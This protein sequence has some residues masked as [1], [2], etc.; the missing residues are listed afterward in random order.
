MDERLIR[1]YTENYM[2]KV[3]YYCLKR[4]GSGTE[5]DDLAGDITQQI[6][7]ALK[8]GVVPEHFPAWV[9]QISHNRYR[10][11]AEWK[12]RHAER[13][14]DADI[15]T[16]E[17]TETVSDPAEDAVLG[18]QLALLRRELALIRTDYR[19]ILTA[20]YLENRPVR[21]IARSLSLSESAVKKRLERAR[22]LLKEGMEM[23]RT[24]GKL[25]YQPEN[26][27]FIN[28]G[29]F[30]SAGEPWNYI[31]RS[32]CKNILLAAYRT[33]STAEELSL[34]L[35]VALPYMEEELGSLV[36]A[37]LMKKNG[38]LY[39]TTFFI[40]SAAAQEA[41]NAHR[42]QITP[43]LTEDII[44]TVEYETAQKNRFC[45]GWHEGYQPYEDMK[46]ALLME[47][48]DRVYR[49]VLD[50]R[51]G[52]KPL[53]PAKLGPWG[54]T[55]RP[56]GG[57]WDI[58]GMEIYAGEHPAFVGLHGCVASPEEQNLPEVDFGQFKF[59]YREIAQKTPG[60]LH[61]AEGAALLAAAR[62]DV[63]AVFPAI[64]DSLTE[65]GYLEKKGDT[66][67][68]T[69]LVMF[70]EKNPPLPEEEEHQLS[71][72]REKAA[73]TAARHYLFCREQVLAEIPSFLQND[74][75]QIEHACANLFDL[76]GAVLEEALRTG[77]ITYADDDPRRMLG[78]VLRG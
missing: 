4:T 65:A 57:E 68:P 74:R 42:K 56:N 63:S 30:G 17:E 61:H 67:L 76:R 1:E 54:H 52:D 25:S 72:L 71:L 55:L 21:E 69:F 11:W 26:I 47:E 39:K 23:A 15:E 41:V 40:V 66:Y 48:V 18:E 32:L 5:A 3:F 44:R 20:Y 22:N 28:N 12:H 43:A 6:I 53:P 24:F 49:Q 34:E 60:M 77:Y 38:K 9:W 19:E 50:S 29:L 7:A 31:S 35:G 64:L 10:L 78:A 14:S 58:L 51:P 45:P 59:Q 37:T 13:F 33:P 62:G 2:G 73:E 8:S 27:A 36:D 16:L 70:K 46:W 75:Y